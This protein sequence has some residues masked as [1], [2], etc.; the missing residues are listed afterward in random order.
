[1]FCAGVF[2]AAGVVCAFC[3]Y[4][5][6]GSNAGISVWFSALL[7]G[8]MHGVNMM[9]ISILPPYFRRYGLTGTASGMLNACTYVGSALSTYG[10]AAISEVIG[11]KITVLLWALIALLGM[12]LCLCGTKVFTKKFQF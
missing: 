8:S 1:M 7:T 12:L 10:I 3:L 9:L 5:V 6:T 2:F 4:A 11:W